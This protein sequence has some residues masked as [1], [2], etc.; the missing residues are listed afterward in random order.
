MA[1]NRIYVNEEVDQRLRTMKARTRLTPNLLCRLGF[2][3]G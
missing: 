2:R 3:R 1:L